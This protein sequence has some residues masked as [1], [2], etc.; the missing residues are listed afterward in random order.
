MRSILQYNQPFGAGHSEQSS[1]D[2]MPHNIRILPAVSDRVPVCKFGA[3]PV[4]GSSSQYSVHR[5]ENIC[6]LLLRNII[7]NECEY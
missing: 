4:C 3:G 1:L 7:L 6:E 2:A 5:F